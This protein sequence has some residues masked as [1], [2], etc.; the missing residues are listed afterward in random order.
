MTIGGSSAGAASV[1][2]QLSAYSGRDDKL[3]SGAAAESQSFGAQYTVEESQYI[4][5]GLVERV[6]CK[7]SKDTLQC[8]RKLDVSVIAKHNSALPTPGGA[9]GE[10]IFGY[11]DVIDGD[12]VAD[13]TYNLF[14]KGKF[15][16]VPTIFGYVPQSSC[17]CEN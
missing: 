7:T 2:L 13:Y 11:G 9:G 14:A 15:I 16:K 4:Y 8:L 1:V 6:G 17:C 12:F 5:D 3:F 10:P